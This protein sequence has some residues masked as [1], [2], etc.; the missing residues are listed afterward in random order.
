MNVQ[1]IY[2]YVSLCRINWAFVFLLSTLYALFLRKPLCFKSPARSSHHYGS[3][4]HEMCI[5]AL[6]LV[7]LIIITYRNLQICRVSHYFFC[8]NVLVVACF[9][10]CLIS[11]FNFGIVKYI[12]K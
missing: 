5:E 4:C 1:C 2:T 7:A 9:T 3:S 10:K 12:I 8:R 6:A 11:S